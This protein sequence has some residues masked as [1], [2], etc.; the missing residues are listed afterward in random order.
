M[1]DTPE[2]IPASFQVIPH[3]EQ[4]NIINRV[5]GDAYGLTALNMVALHLPPSQAFELTIEQY[6]YVAVI[7]SGVCD[8]ETSRGNYE[9]V[10][11]RGDVFNGLPYAV[12]IPPE[13]EFTVN[14]LTEDVSLAMCWTATK[15]GNSMQLI[16]PKDVQTEVIHHDQASYQINTIVPATQSQQLVVR[17]LYIPG[18]NWGLYPPKQ[19]QDNDESRESIYLCK[20]NKNGGF[21]LGTQ[22]DSDG[23]TTGLHAQHNDIFVVASGYHSFASP[24]E[25]TT[26]LLH[27]SNGHY[28]TVTSPTHDWIQPRMQAD[29]RLPIVDMGM[30]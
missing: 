1:T 27:V 9:Q 23:H 6:E 4:G 25:Y 17:E 19:Y 18:G 13:T 7:L 28:H 20:H 5:G 15:R 21:T 8:I 16:E 12:Y 26:Y 22:I 2:N 14:A 10:G 24:P 30:E 29:R 11:R 3:R